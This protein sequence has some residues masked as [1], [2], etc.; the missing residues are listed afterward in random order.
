MHR[1][2]P[3]CERYLGSLE[4]SA[5]RRR[6]LAFAF[7]AK[8]EARANALGFQ[9]GDLAGVG[10]TAMAADNAGRPYD[11]FERFAGGSFI[12]EARVLKFG[13]HGAWLL[14]S[15]IL[16]LAPLLSRL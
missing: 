7:V 9:L 8:V 13:G 11:S 6:E 3:F 5:D 12:G 15:A 4:N 1:Q 16:P 10:V 2:P 14:M